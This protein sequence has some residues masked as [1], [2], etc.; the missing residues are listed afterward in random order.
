VKRGV[1]HV[2]GQLTW[3]GA[4]QWNYFNGNVSA[5]VIQDVAD[6]LHTTGLAELGFRQI[7]IDSG[8]LLR[9]RAADGS[10]QV[11]PL[12]RVLLQASVRL[13]RRTLSH[14]PPRRATYLI[15]ISLPSFRWTVPNS[16]MG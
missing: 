9:E 12:L 7:N 16:P 10:L 14:M 6:A 11:S 5:E 1:P 3:T 2:R 13:D 4:L 15:H 8:Y